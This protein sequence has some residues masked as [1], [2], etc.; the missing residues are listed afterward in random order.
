MNVCQTNTGLHAASSRLKNKQ[1]Q[2]LQEQRRLE[3]MRRLKKAERDR[4]AKQHE[5]RLKERAEMKRREEEEGIVGYEEEEDDNEETS[6]STSPQASQ[7]VCVELKD[8]EVLSQGNDI[9][10]CFG[11]HMVISLKS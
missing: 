9:N 5:Q 2:E 1:E 7:T 8:L 11:L 3:K 4:M 6:D 10:G